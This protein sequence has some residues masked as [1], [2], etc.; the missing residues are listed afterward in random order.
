[1]KNSRGVSS[2]MYWDRMRVPVSG[3]CVCVGGWVCAS[4]AVY[5][6]TCTFY[7]SA[8]SISFLLVSEATQI[9]SCTHT[10]TYECVNSPHTTRT[11]VMKAAV[12]DFTN[13]QTVR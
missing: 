11:P 8:E 3:V 2:R 12:V 4:L 6:C 9:S 1:M 10:H 5:T 7:N 13:S